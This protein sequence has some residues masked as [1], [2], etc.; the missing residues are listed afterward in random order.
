MR[1]TT[2]TSSWYQSTSAVIDSGLRRA[3]SIQVSNG[4]HTSA[5]AKPAT[6]RFQPRAT[7]VT[8]GRMPTVPP[9]TSVLMSALPFAS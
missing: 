1:A 8:R 9:A 4:P 2:T 6:C 5:T 7:P 3:N